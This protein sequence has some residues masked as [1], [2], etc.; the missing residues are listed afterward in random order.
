[1]K[2]YFLGPLKLLFVVGVAFLAFVGF[3]NFLV[4]RTFV[5]VSLGYSMCNLRNP[6][7][8]FLSLRNTTCS[9]VPGDAIIVSQV[10]PDVNDVVCANTQMGMICHR[11]YEV[12]DDHFCFI[13]DAAKWTACYPW[14]AYA[15]KV[16]GKVP[17]S[18]AMPGVL[19]WGTARGYFA[20]WQL[21]DSGSY[22]L[23][24]S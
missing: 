5:S 15:G 21:I 22:A 11:A 18:V 12:T 2:D 13:G 23:A 20:V 1:V 7:Y 19:L 10:P 4:P 14:D 9:I 17:R 6:Y 3:V 8:D 16:V 24:R